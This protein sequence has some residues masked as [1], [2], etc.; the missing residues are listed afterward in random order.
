[1]KQDYTKYTT[2]DHETWSILV[3]RQHKLLEGKAAKK[4]FDGIEMLNLR[5]PKVP[6]F[7]E[8]NNILGR[9]TGW[10]IIAADGIVPAKEF[11]EHLANKRFPSTTWLRS[12][13]SLDYI[14]EPD[15]FHDVFGHT[16]ILA[17]KEFTT[18]LQRFAEI[19]LSIKN[20]EWESGLVS[21]VY[22]HTVEFGLMKEDAEL[23]IYGAGILSSPGETGYVF[24]SKPSK[25]PFDFKKI[26]NSIYA[27][28][29]YQEEYFVI[30]SFTQLYSSLDNFEE[31]VLNEMQDRK[32]R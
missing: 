6:D 23:K 7:N 12:K 20:Y 16:P 18:Y 15:I 26:F 25:I 13:D 22:W 32:F 1:M 5:Q 21:S 30:D 4:F 2:E 24:T 27:I 17:D 19:T 10:E 31:K 8:I 14:E 3:E 11:F 28:D 29:Q 9:E